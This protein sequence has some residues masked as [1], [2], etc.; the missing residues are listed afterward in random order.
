MENWTQ[1]YVRSLFDYH[2]ESGWLVWKYNPNKRANW[3]ARFASEAAGSM[4]GNGYINVCIDG[5]KYGAH[6]IIFLWLHGY[7]PEC[8]D[9][10]D[11]CPWN[12]REHN[13]KECTH[14]QNVF[15]AK[16]V[17]SEGVERHGAKYRVRIGARENR[18]TIGS[19]D[20]YEQA[21]EAYRTASAEIYGEFAR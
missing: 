5:I 6:R 7:V 16:C 21:H 10:D 13:L 14:A 17:E 18:V 2:A 9:H 8:I 15:K 4:A 19:Y 11:D 1:D 20:T 12:N 3:N